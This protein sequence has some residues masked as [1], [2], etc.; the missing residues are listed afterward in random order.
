MFDFSSLF[1]GF[2]GLGGFKTPD[3]NPN[4]SPENEWLNKM[5]GLGKQSDPTADYLKSIGAGQSQNPFASLGKMAPYLASVQNSSPPMQAPMASAS[6]GSAGSVSSFAGM[7]PYQGLM[8]LKPRK[9]TFG[10]L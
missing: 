5:A 1:G 7:S 2:G 10:G 3:F 4:A 8:Q 9:V 6:R